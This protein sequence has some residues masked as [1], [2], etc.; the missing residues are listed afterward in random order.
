MYIIQDLSGQLWGEYILAPHYDA[1]K[2]ADTAC[3]MLNSRGL[4]CVVMESRRT[5]RLKPRN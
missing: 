1:K 2:M 3:S 4:P 5:E